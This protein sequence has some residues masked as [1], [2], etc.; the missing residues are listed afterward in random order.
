[1]AELVELG[2][3]ES[4]KLAASQPLCKVAWSSAS[5]PVILPINHV[6]HD[7]TVWFRTSAYSAI[8][9][10]VDDETIAILVD[11]VDVETRTGWSVQLR[12]IAHVHWHAEEVPDAVHHLHSWASGGRPLWVELRP[13]EIHGR[14]LLSGD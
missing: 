12:G 5:G 10:E 2:Q 14:R 6:I 7:R 9:R 11:E 13:T 4:W 1:M 8:V 3:D